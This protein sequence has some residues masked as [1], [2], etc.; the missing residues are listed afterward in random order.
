[1]KSMTRALE[2][3]RSQPSGAEMLDALSS[4]QR[5][6][7][8]ASLSDDEADA[9]L[10]DWEFWARPNQ[11]EPTDRPWV[12]WL[13]MA[14]RG[15]GKTRVGSEQIRKWVKKFP[16]VN[17]IGA[18]AADVRD[19]M[20]QGIGAGSAIMEVC[21]RDERPVYEKSNRR[22]VW[23]NGAVS[24]LFSAEEP[25]RLRG[26]QC[27]KGWCDDVAAWKYPSEAWEQFE[28]GL[29][30]GSDPQVVVT[31]TPKPTK[32][33]KELVANPATAVTRG[34]TYD[35]KANL[36][37]N[38]FHSIIRK[39]EGTRL[40]RQE[41]M[42]ELLDDRPGALWTLKAIDADRVCQCPLLTR[43]VVGTDP[44]VTSGDDSAEWGILFVGMGP[45]P[46]GQ[47]WPPHFYVIDDWSGKFS[48][49]DAAKRVVDGYQV[50]KADRIVAEVNNGGDL[51]EAVLRNVD[52]SFAYKAV[53]A[54]RGKLTRA[55]PIAA[56]YEQHR[57]HHVGAFGVLEDQMC[58][59]VPL[60][61]KSPDRMDAL[62]WAL[63][64]L[65]NPE[66]VE[67]FEDYNEP[68]SISPELDQFDDLP[69]FWVM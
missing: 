26:P 28:F 58:D 64:E 33:I 68:I 25:E 12:N 20:V 36:A 61:A 56:L 65:N 37:K 4:E 31:T 5:R 54:S 22:L 38:F 40:G 35:N 50:H 13:V 23:P 60:V 41:L 32:L 30:L 42:A 45:S 57:V 43:I 3:Q 67:M 55:E 18:T 52:H 17:L 15:F 47:V 29:R 19:V 48:P 10:H 59:Y 63:W 6:K 39:Y 21:R 44:A 16:I 46:N 24:L 9:L 66:E 53:H 2:T 7:W 27:H 51:V 62:V 69:D 1:M 49:N 34:S 8:F 14:G 11:L